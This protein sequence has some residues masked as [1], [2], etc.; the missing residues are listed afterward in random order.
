MF[1][2]R[3]VPWPQFGLASKWQVAGAPLVWKRLGVNPRYQSYGIFVVHLFQDFIRHFE[4]VDPPEC[5]ALAI[6]FKI[7][8]ARLQRA[9]IP[10]V[11]SEEHTSELQSPSN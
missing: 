7:F 1:R 2:T 4:T 10:F 6:I 9:E 5:M 8:V 11:R 3:A